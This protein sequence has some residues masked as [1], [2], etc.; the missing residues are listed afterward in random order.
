MSVSITTLRVLLVEDDAVLSE[1]TRNYLC[2]HNHEVDVASSL[3][4]AKKLLTQQSYDVLVLDLGLP[5]GDGL[6][7]CKWLRAQERYQNFPVLML[8][9]RDEPVDRVVGLELGADDYLG[10]P[11]EPR[12]LLARLRALMR[13]C[14]SLESAHDIGRGSQQVPT[15]YTYGSLTVDAECRN[16]YLHDQPVA[17]TPYQFDL[18][19]LFCKNSGR[20]L[21]RDFIMSCLRQNEL[22]IY[23]RSI[24]VVVS[25]LRAVLEVNPKEPKRILTIR[26]VGYVFAKAQM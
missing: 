9:A 7:F 11:F 17:L 4:Q 22:D 6:D 23:D 25:K 1:L 21:S 19:L 12:E 5:D 24:D 13:R 26:G 3:G 15:F 20:V 16:V 18:L 14:K 8:T 2:E 10:K